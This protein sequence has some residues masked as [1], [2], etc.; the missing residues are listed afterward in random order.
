MKRRGDYQPPAKQ[1]DLELAVLEAMT[2]H[3]GY[4]W[5]ES[6]IAYV[7]GVSRQAIRHVKRSGMRNLRERLQRAILGQ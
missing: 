3:L 5:S 7:C 1:Y 4:W 2:P 6:D